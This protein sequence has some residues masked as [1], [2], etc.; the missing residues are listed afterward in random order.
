MFFFSASRALTYC[1]PG[2]VLCY[3]KKPCLACLLIRSVDNTEFARCCLRADA[4]G[5]STGS[6]SRTIELGP[7]NSTRKQGELTLVSRILR[8]LNLSLAAVRGPPRL[9]TCRSAAVPTP[10]TSRPSIAS[11]AALTPFQMTEFTT[12]GKALTRGSVR[13]PW[14][15]FSTS[16]SASLKSS[17]WV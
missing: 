16:K 11:S 3:C 13:E 9:I 6:C 5:S 10:T 12:G 17:Q 15:R 4:I 1:T 2:T 14:P 8:Y 7:M